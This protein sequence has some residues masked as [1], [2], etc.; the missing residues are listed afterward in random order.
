[1][2]S[3]S[4]RE[5]KIDDLLNKAKGK[6]FNLS[7]NM[8]LLDRDSDDFQETFCLSVDLLYVVETI[9]DG[10]G[11]TLDEKLTLL[12]MIAEKAKL[13]EQPITD[14][15]ACD[16]YKGIVIVNSSGVTLPITGYDMIVDVDPAEFSGNTKAT[17]Q[18]VFD[19]IYTKLN[20]V[21]STGDFD[22]GLLTN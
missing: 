4:Y 12:E 16:L 13:S 14:Y 1:M 6:L 22:G 5:S 18:E 21:D 2:S 19:D 10:T 9:E 20:N 17:A 15:G 7:Y 11:L 8:T 3:P